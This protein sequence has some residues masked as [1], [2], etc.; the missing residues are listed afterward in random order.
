ML[1][2]SA[3]SALWT[4]LQHWMGPV[5]QDPVV[6]SLGAGVEAGEAGLGRGEPGV[7]GVLG[8]EM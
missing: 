5:L 4:L 2:A 6:G 8:A 1:L 7:L 3:E